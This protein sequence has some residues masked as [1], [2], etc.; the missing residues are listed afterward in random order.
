MA[1]WLTTGGRYHRDECTRVTRTHQNQA[2][3]AESD[4]LFPVLIS[5]PL[6]P[7]FSHSLCF[8]PSSLSQNRFQA[9]LNEIIQQE[10]TETEQVSLLAHGWEPPAQR[11]CASQPRLTRPLPLSS[12]SRC[13]W[14]I[15]L[16]ILQDTGL[17][18]PI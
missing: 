13:T 1:F 3:T 6:P 11:H 15:Q 14:A 12:H 2:Q 9:L 7:P 16:I 10:D 17:I 4:I 18:S 5:L 8:S